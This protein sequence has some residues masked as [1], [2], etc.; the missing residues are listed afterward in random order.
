MG[1]DQIWLIDELVVVKEQIQIDASGPPPRGPLAAH[2]LLDGL[3]NGQQILGRVLSG[4]LHY[5]V[6]KQGLILNSYRLRLI[7]RRR[8]QDLHSLILLKKI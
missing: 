1:N 3:Q 4:Q 2:T 8:A 5:G 7:Q 6:Q